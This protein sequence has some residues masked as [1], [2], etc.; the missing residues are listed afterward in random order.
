[1]EVALIFLIPA[2]GFAI[3]GLISPAGMWEVTQSWRYKNT[4]AN[5][6]SE[7]QHAMTRVGSG[8]C[9]VAVVIMIPLIFQ[10][11]E[12]NQRE[13]E[14]ENYQD[15]LVENRDSDGLLSAEDWCED[16]APEGTSSESDDDSDYDSDYDSEYD[17]D[18]DSDYGSEYDGF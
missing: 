3:W 15:C 18:Y 6:P 10:V 7:A 16:L 1:M 13:Q 8:V 17:S 2:A 12:Q 9:L 11:G 14:E 5:R 4:E